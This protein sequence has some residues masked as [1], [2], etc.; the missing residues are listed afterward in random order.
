MNETTDQ[1]AVKCSFCGRE[2]NEVNSMVAGPDVYICDIC[3]K[4]SVDILKNNLAAYNTKSN[5]Q[6]TLTPDMIKKSLDEYVI[7]QD[8]AKKVLS[9]AVYNHYKRINSNTSFFELDDVEIEKSNIL[10]IGSTGVGKTLIAQTLAKILDVP[11]AIAD[12][13]TLTEAGYVGDDVE[14]ILVR[15]LQSADYNLEKAQ[16][17][18]I[19]IDELDKV[20]RK[21]ES[22]SITRD[23]SGEGVQ[24]ALLKILE[25]TVAG[26]PPKGGRK[27]PEQSLININTKNILFICGGAFDGIDPIIASR[28]NTNTMGFDTEVDKKIIEKDDLVQLVQPEDLISYGLIPEL[29]G[30]LPVAAPLHSLNEEALKNILTKPKNAILKQYKK[31]FMMEGIDLEFEEGALDIIVK[32]AIERK[33]GARALRSIVENTLL[34]IMY[35]IPNLEDIDKCL[36]TKDTI[37][38]GEPPV[39]IEADRKSA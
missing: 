31:L 26:V 2:A 38:K 23:V 36:I 20:A 39:Y 24:Q 9:V 17:G 34:D 33:T 6:T 28:I 27:H 29:V 18:I 15:L 25:G 19:Y 3:I 16:K 35:E 5:Q 11:F 10:M 8:R 14:T 4:T 37:E 21:S 1:K 12:A 30:R 32:T 7:G 13:T 22:V